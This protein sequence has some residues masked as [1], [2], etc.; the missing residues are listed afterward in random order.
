MFQI[1][2][3][4]PPP[5]VPLAFLL[6]TWVGVGV[7]D[8]PTIEGFRFGQEIV[9]SHAGKPVLTYASRSWLLDEEGRRVRPLA[10]ETGYWRPVGQDEGR[11]EVVLAH[12][13]GIAEIWVGEVSGAKIEL[14]T[15]VVARTESAKPVTAGHRLYGVVEGDLMYAY[16]MAAMGQPLTPHVSARLKPVPSAPLSGDTGDGQAAGA[17]ST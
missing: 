1:P 2:A 3:D 16:D 17:E 6:G 11:V 13:T 10:S 8:Y 7:G 15:D 14:S 9:F 5:L 12:P 4:L